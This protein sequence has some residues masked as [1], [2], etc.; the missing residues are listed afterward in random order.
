MTKPSP[1]PLTPAQVAAAEAL[2]TKAKV[3]LIV[4]HPFFASLLMARHMKAINYGTFGVDKR[5]TV[6]YSP[7]FIVND[8]LS[9]GQVKFGLCHEALHVAGLDFLRV[10]ERDTRK[11]NKAADAYIN[12]VLRSIGIGEDIPNTINK[13]GSKELTKE[14]IYANW[15]DDPG[16]GGDEYEPGGGEGDYAP[17]EGGYGI[18]DDF[19]DDGSAP[20]SEAER[21]QIEAEVKTAVAQAAQAAKMQGKL[22]GQLE[23]FVKELLE[24]KTPWFEKLERFMTAVSK[25]DLSWKRPNRRFMH[26]GTYLPSLHSQCAMGTMVF[27]VDTSGS[28]GGKELQYAA[29]HL[30]RIIE[31]C[32]PEKVVVIYCDAAVNM[33]EEFGVD[34]YPVTMKAV[35][36]GGTDFRPVFGHVSETMTEAPACL[37]YFTDMG[38]TFPDAPP[39]YPTLW[40]NIHQPANPPFGEEV[41]FE[42]ED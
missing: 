23:R 11:W 2:V 16:G 10:Q 26:Q 17:G 25:A 35:G 8:K 37:I 22:P 7:R 18:G 34:D 28:I 31:V 3:H 24:V 42:M 32:K 38:G 21:S 9:L 5:G 13:P 41:M 40:L 27:A 1:K 12:D 4:D 14:E 20:L 15:Q 6:Y 33:V 36:G 29:G 30:N 19:I 39:P